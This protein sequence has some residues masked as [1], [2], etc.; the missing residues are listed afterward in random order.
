M[1]HTEALAR[2]VHRFLRR[3]TVRSDT[4]KPWPDP[5]THRPGATKLVAAHTGIGWGHRH[6]VR[7]HRKSLRHSEPSSP[8]NQKLRAASL[9]PS[10]PASHSGGATCNHDFRLC[11]SMCLYMEGDTH[12][13]GVR[14]TERGAGATPLEGMRHSRLTNTPPSPQTSRR[15]RC[16]LR[17]RALVD[18]TPAHPERFRWQHQRARRP[19]SDPIDPR[20]RLRERRAPD[21][22]R[23]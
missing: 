5:S 4:R 6:I 3:S 19:R 2:F 12:Q 21:T 15:A 16:V 14:G 20:A 18:A 8:H 13:P 22:R 11:S 23:A 9:H 1:R 7:A 17:P 10:D